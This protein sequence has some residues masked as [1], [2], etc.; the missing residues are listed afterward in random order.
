MFSVFVNSMPRM[1]TDAVEVQLH[2]SLTSVQYGGEKS[3]S[4]FTTFT[5]PRSTLCKG[6]GTWRGEDKTPEH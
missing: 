3:D 6:D 2:T 4:H 1:T 5:L